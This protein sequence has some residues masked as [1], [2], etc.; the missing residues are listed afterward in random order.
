MSR[1]STRKECKRSKRAAQ[2]EHARKRAMTRYGLKL[3]TEVHDDIVARIHVSGSTLVRRQ[4]NRVSIHDVLLN[5][6]T[7]RVAYDCQRR[8][9]VTFLYRDEN[10]WPTKS[11]RGTS[12]T[13]P[14]P[15]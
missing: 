13:P 5:A 3:T 9:L 4:S 15:T 11:L 10:E 12:P 2:F 8:V 14:L 7:Y 6:K 1:R